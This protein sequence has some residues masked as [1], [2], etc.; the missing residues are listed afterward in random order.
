MIDRKVKQK[1]ELECKV[2]GFICEDKLHRQH[3]PYCK[4]VKGQFNFLYP[5]LGKE[6]V[7]K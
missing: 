4:K 7:I 5:R 2:C 1:R 6:V 3:C